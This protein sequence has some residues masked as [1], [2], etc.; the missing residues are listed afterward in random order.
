MKRLQAAIANAN[1]RAVSVFLTAGHPTMEASEANMRAAIAGGADFI[2]VGIPFS[3]PVAD[4]PIIEAASNQALAG[5]TTVAGVL[6]MVARVRKDHPEVGLVAMTYA[7]IAHRRGWQKFAQDLAGA[8]MDGAILPDAPLE[9][10]AGIRAALA[11]HGLAWIPLVTPTTPA[12][13]MAA[14]ADTATGFLYVVGN[15]GIT[16]QDDPGPLIEGVVG[17]A[18]AAGAT[19]PLV[20]GFGLRTAGDVE[21]VWEAGA[22]GAIVGSALVEKIS[23]GASPDDVQAFVQALCA[24]KD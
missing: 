16:G 24:S 22:Q 23:A 14:I 8:G 9:E 3:D 20:V 4:G 15:V 6:D 1:G 12:D 18:K 10:S 13:R 17:K 2:E 19:V 21:R 5:G 7:N 11:D